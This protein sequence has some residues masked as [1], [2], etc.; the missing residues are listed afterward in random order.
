MDS[1]Q[2]LYER[3]IGMFNLLAYMIENKDFDVINI[4]EQINEQIEKLESE[5]YDSFDLSE[6][7]VVLN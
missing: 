1:K 2:R 3:Y 4:M 5:G 6:L 7:L